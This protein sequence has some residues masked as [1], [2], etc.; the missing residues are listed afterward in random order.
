MTLTRSLNP[1]LTSSK[2]GL[3]VICTAYSGHRNAYNLIN[4]FQTI[5]L[6]LDSMQSSIL[7]LAVLAN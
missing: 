7:I 3:F 6:E 2:V 4:L 5:V 1:D